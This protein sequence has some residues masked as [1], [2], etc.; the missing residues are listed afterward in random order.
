MN[1]YSKELAIM[2]L[3]D[4]RQI[5]IETNQVHLE[6]LSLVDNW[7]KRPGIVRQKT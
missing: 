3:Q 6:N 7:E 1:R 5:D 2:P 4:G